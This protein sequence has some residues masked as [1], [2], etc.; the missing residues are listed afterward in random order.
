MDEF[1]AKLVAKWEE[2]L[3]TA[4]QS[5]KESLSKGYEKLAAQKAKEILNI[6]ECIKDLKLPIPEVKKNEIN[7]TVF[8]L[9][10]EEREKEHVTEI[11][12]NGSEEGLI[13]AFEDLLKTD[14]GEFIA[15]SFSKALDNVVAKVKGK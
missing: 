10:I 9:E 2:R 14:Q 3:H 1:T 6:K 12:F 8:C 15:N 11:I 13:K 4:E 5:H 7:K